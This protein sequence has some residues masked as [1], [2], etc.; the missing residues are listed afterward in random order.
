MYNLKWDNLVVSSSEDESGVD[1]NELTDLM[2]K[3]KRGIRTNLNFREERKNH[4]ANKPKVT[5]AK[6]IFNTTT[7]QTPSNQAKAL[8]GRAFSE[9]DEVIS[10]FLEKTLAKAT[11]KYE[12]ALT[13]KKSRG[14][15]VLNLKK[16]EALRPSTTPKERSLKCGRS[17]DYPTL[18]VSLE[19]CSGKVSA[20]FLYNFG[21]AGFGQYPDK[22]PCGISFDDLNPKVVAKLGEP[23]RKGKTFNIWIEY[24]NLGLIIDFFST[25]WD[26][27]RSSI[28]FVTVIKAVCG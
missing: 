22:L 20:V 6:D 28:K 8:L 18:G 10:A 11:L 27:L 1:Q 5:E 17:I 16:F 14:P 4:P 19:L 13:E 24:P 26:D 23:G 15:A 2:Q 21:N 7:I 9:N 12:K 25:S 3:V